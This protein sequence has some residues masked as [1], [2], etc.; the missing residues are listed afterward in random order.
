MKPQAPAEVRGP[1][2]PIA[3]AVPGVH[4]NELMP[5]LAKL[6]RHYSLIRSM[7]HTA[8]IRNHPDAMHN[9]LTGQAK[10]PGRGPSRQTPRHRRLALGETGKEARQRQ[11]LRRVVRVA[12]GVA[13]RSAQLRPR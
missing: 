9:C 5:R 7:T 13:D 8:P 6:G 10:A 1:F 11:P 4:I 12:P 3:T 2:K